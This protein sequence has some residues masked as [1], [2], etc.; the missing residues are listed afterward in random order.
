MGLSC[1]DE[2]RK[3]THHRQGGPRMR[4]CTQG[5]IARQVS[6]LRRQFLQDG[7]LPFREVLTAEL[8]SQA[9]TAIGACWNDRIFTPLV[10]VYSCIDSRIWPAFF[11]W[12]VLNICQ[13]SS[14]HPAGLSMAGIK[15]DWTEPLH[16]RSLTPRPSHMSRVFPPA[17]R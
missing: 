13:D 12:R 15:G 7:D 14:P 8:I 2:V 10:S 1:V 6:F 5:R 4:H 17:K 11:L 3:H 16:G 9:L